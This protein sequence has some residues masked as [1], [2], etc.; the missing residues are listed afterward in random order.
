MNYTY[1]ELQKL[2]ISKQEELDAALEREAVAFRY[3]TSESAMWN[4]VDW[5]GPDEV[6]KDNFE[7]QYLSASP[8]P[9]EQQP[10]QDVAALA[11]QALELKECIADSN[12]MLGELRKIWQK[13]MPKSAQDVQDQ[14]H[15]GEEL[16]IAKT[17]SA[18]LARRDLIK[19]AE[20]LEEA[21]SV[22][23]QARRDVATVRALDEA[24]ED[25]E[26]LRQQAK[27]L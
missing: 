17:S 7:I 15:R 19:Q 10:A 22:M 27:E 4:Y 9:V 3:R 2:L 16:I 18:I 21:L 6:E 11:A 20:A 24:I 13:K 12:E 26:K 1:E 25:V 23:R 14:I 5:R 8:Q